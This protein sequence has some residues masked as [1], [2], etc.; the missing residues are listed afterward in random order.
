MYIENMYFLESCVMALSVLFYI[1][2]SKE[3]VEKQ[4]NYLLKSTIYTILG[5]ISYQGT[6]G[7]IFLL[8]T[9]MTFIKNPKDYKSNICDIIKSGITAVIAVSIDM[10]IVKEFE[11]IIGITQTRLGEISNI[12][13][14]IKKKPATRQKL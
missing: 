7:F 12:T 9:L 5:V 13:T 8:T 2:S 1:L 14:N 10:C 3:L 11:K 6:I 4:K